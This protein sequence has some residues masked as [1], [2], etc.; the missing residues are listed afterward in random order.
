MNKILNYISNGTGFGIKFLLIISLLSSVFITFYLHE[1]AQIAIPYAQQTADKLLPITIRN[2]KIVE[3][4]N[5]V[6]D[7]SIHLGTINGRAQKLPIILNTYIDTLNISQLT[8]GI[9]LTR[10]YIYIVQKDQI[11]THNYPESLDLPQAD[12]KE[13]F[14]SLLNYIT[15]SFWIF[16]VLGVFIILF[17]SATFYSFT[18]WLL[19]K[20][21]D[22]EKEMDFDSRMR[23]SVLSLFGVYILKFALGA[24][25]IVFGG[26]IVFFTIILI[27][28]VYLKKL[29]PKPEKQ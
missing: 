26:W 21:L 17:I 24:A 8:A 25:G 20:F 12:Y 2:K 14:S 9:Y 28:A 3:P 13:E 1:K 11:R 15:L 7:A 27:Q 29:P 18:A 23:L 10:Q 4:V 16:C 22:K 19:S 6:R 5:T